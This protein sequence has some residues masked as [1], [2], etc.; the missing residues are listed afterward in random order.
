LKNLKINYRRTS[1]SNW[2]QQIHTVSKPRIFD[3]KIITKANLT[4][5]TSCIFI[6]ACAE[7]FQIKYISTPRIDVPP[8]PTANPAALRKKKDGRL[9]RYTHE[10]RTFSTVN[11]KTAEVEGATCTMSSKEIKMTVTTPAKLGM[12]MLNREASPHL[13]ITCK[14][15]NQTGS[16]AIPLQFFDAAPTANPLSNI[17]AK[18]IAKGLDRYT[19]GI[20]QSQY[21]SVVLN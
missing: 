16:V 6:T 15:Q 14:K 20:G 8:L 10:L 5:L 3:M 13:A 11:G 18:G 19:Y 9:H 4:A 1:K 7:T 12:P 2:K 17:L 21:M